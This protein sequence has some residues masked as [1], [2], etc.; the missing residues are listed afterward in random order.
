MTKYRKKP[1]VIDAF[2]WTGGPDQTE[3][4]QWI[5]ERIK[6]GQVSFAN[7]LMYIKTLEGIMEAK[8]G[9]Y[10]IRGV[11]GEI[12]PCKPDIFEATYESVA[13]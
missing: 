11:K 7:G 3:D 2:K 13:K 9:D 6:M 1:V 8:P 12:Y 5:I 4:P 10:I